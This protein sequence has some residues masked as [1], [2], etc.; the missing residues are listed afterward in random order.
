GQ[1]IGL[2]GNTGR[3]YGSH[4]HFETR[5]L[6][7]T[8]NPN[9]IIDFDNKVTH[10]DEYLVTNSSYRKTT[11]SSKVLVTNPAVYKK[12][13]TATNKYVSSDVIYHRIKS[14]DTLGD[15]SRHY[16]IS[17]KDICDMN[18]ITTKTVLRVGKSLR[19]S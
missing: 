13:T 6:G 2:A 9:F 7:K 4:L 1:P 10:R 19:I 15:I 17:L 11:N 5:F 14:V 8:I 16:G 12:P 3:S 18:N